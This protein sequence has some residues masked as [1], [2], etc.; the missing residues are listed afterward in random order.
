VSAEV[1]PGQVWRREDGSEWEA[2]EPISDIYWK[3]RCVRIDD[4]GYFKVNSVDHSRELGAHN[5]VLVA[6]APA[7]KGEGKPA[8]RVGQVWLHSF[9]GV[10]VLWKIVAP[11][12]VD[13]WVIE[14]NSGHRCQVGMVSTKEWTL[15]Q[16]A[17]AEPKVA[18]KWH[19][20]A[21]FGF[22]VPRAEVERIKAA[23]RNG[24]LTFPAKPLD[25]NAADVAR[26]ESHRRPRSVPQVADREAFIAGA[27]AT[28]NDA[29][30][31]RPFVSG[32]NRRSPR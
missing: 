15:V 29:Y 32:W 17:P 9:G 27:M 10:A 7:A 6:E 8:V 25:A 21:D 1:R 23:I 5:Y 31:T 24:C 22:D 16:D 3:A 11:A 19:V 4:R 18:M 12:P 14:D 28:I 13:G 20:G 30:A 26:S 2:I